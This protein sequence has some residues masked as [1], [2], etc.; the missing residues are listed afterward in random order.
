MPI[1]DEVIELA[2]VKKT[3]TTL[4]ILL[5]A[6]GVAVALAVTF[7]VMYLLKP[8]PEGDN[9]VVN[10]VSITTNSLF[11]SL[12][13][14]GNETLTASIGNKYTV[15]AKASVE[16]GT[17]ENI[18]WEVSPREAVID[19]QIS[20]DTLS[21][22]FTP[23]AGHDGEEVTII[24]RSAAKGE[25]VKE[26]KFKVVDQKTEYLFATKYYAEGTDSS[27]APT[28][29]DNK[30]SVPHYT[31]NDNNKSYTMLFEQK[32]EYNDLINEYA[33][34]TDDEADVTATSGDTNVLSIIRSSYASVT[35]RTVKQGSTTINLTVNSGKTFTFNVTVQSSEDLKYIENIYFF[36]KAIVDKEFIEKH[37]TPDNKL[38]IA[39]LTTEFGGSKPTNTTVKM[40]SGTFTLPYSNE[41]YTNIFDH[42]LIYPINIQYDVK[43]KDFQ[44]NWQ[45]HINVTSS[46]NDIIRPD[47]QTAQNTTTVNLVT[48]GLGSGTLTFEDSASGSVKT[49]QK[50]MYNVVAGNQTGT[51]SVQPYNSDGTLSSTKVGDNGKIAVVPDQKMLYSVAYTLTM[52]GDTDVSSVIDKKLMNLDYMVEFDDD[53][54]EVSTDKEFAEKLKKGVRTQLKKSHVDIVR[55]AG[56]STS[57]TATAFT[58][59][60]SLYVA[61]NANA[62]TTEDT[63][64]PDIKFTKFGTTLSTAEDAA[65]NNRDAQWSKK[66]NVSITAQAKDAALIGKDAA[67]NLV[68]DSDNLPGDITY[69]DNGKGA[70]IH[71]QQ[72]ADGEPLPFNVYELITAKGE[73]KKTVSLDAKGSLRSSTMEPVKNSNGVVVVSG[74]NIVF[75]STISTSKATVSVKVTTMDGGDLGTFTFDIYVIN[76]VDRFA[77]MSDQGV[78]YGYK[79]NRITC[80]SNLT[81]GVSGTRYVYRSYNPQGTAT[82]YTFEKMELYYGAVGDSGK[83]KR[84]EKTGGT[85]AADYYYVYTENEQKHEE[86][87]FTYN[88]SILA[89]AVDLYEKSMKF[90]ENFTTVYAEFTANVSDYYAGKS[91]KTPSHAPSVVQTCNFTRNADSV[92]VY[93]NSGYANDS[94]LI[95]NN[96][97]EYDYNQ[98]AKVYFYATSVVKYS[99]GTEIPVERYKNDYLVERATI[100][101]ASGINETY[102]SDI[103]KPST[104]N[105]YY[106]FQLSVPMVKNN[107]TGDLYSFAVTAGATN[108]NL[109]IRAQNKSRGVAYVGLFSDENCTTP[110]AADTVL[111]FG[112]FN[113]DT[114]ESKTIYVKVTYVELPAGNNPYVN[115]EPV[116]VTLPDFLKSNAENL[117]PSSSVDKVYATGEFEKF[118]LI[119]TL[120]S[121]YDEA[122]N[123]VI[124]VDQ[125]QQPA[126]TNWKKATCNASVDTGLASVSVKDGAITHTATS[127]NSATVEWKVDVA[128]AADFTDGSAKEKVFNLSFASLL[129]AMNY[130][131]TESKLDCTISPATYA[132][133][134]VSKGIFDAD[135]ASIGFTLNNGITEPINKATITVTFTDKTN[136]A[137]TTFTVNFEITV[138]IVVYE[139]TFDNADEVVVFTSGEAGE[140]ETSTTLHVTINGGVTPNDNEL[141]VSVQNADGTTA[142]GLRAVYEKNNEN[143]YTQNVIVYAKNSIITEKTYKVVVSSKGGVKLAEKAITVKTNATYITL[144][145]NHPDVEVTTEEA[146]K[147]YNASVTVTPDKNTFNLAAAI[148]NG[149]DGQTYTVTY[150]V[151]DDAA[152]AASVA[153]QNNGMFTVAP[154][155]RTGQFGYRMTY[156]GSSDKKSYTID[157]VV[158]YTVPS[159][160]NTV[161]LNNLPAAIT[162]NGAIVLYYNSA[163]VRTTID[164]AS[165]IKVTNSFD[166]DGVDIGSMFTERA[167]STASNG[168]LRLEGTKIIPTATTENGVKI[169]IKVGDAES[170]EYTVIVR[171]IGNLVV[172]PSATEIDKT[173]AQ[174]ITLTNSLSNKY[175]GLEYAYAITA[176]AGFTVSGD[177][178]TLTLNDPAP[179][180]GTYRFSAKATFTMTSGI[181]GLA[182][183]CTTFE[184]LNAFNIT[185]NSDSITADFDLICGANTTLDSQNHFLTGGDNEHTV[186]LTKVVS[187]VEYELSVINNVVKITQQFNA[188]GVAKIEVNGSNIGEFTLTVTAKYN[189]TEVVDTVSKTYNFIHI[190]SVTAELKYDNGSAINADT[191][192]NIDDISK[193]FTY[194]VNNVPTGATLDLHAYGEG[195]TTVLNDNVLTITVTKPTTLVVYGTVTVGTGDNQYFVYLPTRTVT[196]T[197]TAPAFNVTSDKN[198]LTLSAGSVLPTATLSVDKAAGFNGAYTVEYTLVSGGDYAALAVNDST[199]TATLTA[200]SVENNGSV[201]VVVRVTVNDGAY[202]GLIYTQEI[203]V[204]VTGVALPTLDLS[205]VI[206]NT[207]ITEGGM[208]N[209]TLPATLNNYSVTYAANVQPDQGI[210]CNLTNSGNTYTLQLNNGAPAGGKIKISVTATIGGAVHSGKTV[211]ATREIIIADPRLGNITN[212][213]LDGSYSCDLSN[214]IRPLYNDGEGYFVKSWDTFTINSIT[215]NGS[216]LSNKVITV[217]GSTVSADIIVDYTMTSGNYKDTN[218]TQQITVSFVQPV[219]VT[220]DY[221]QN[222]ENTATTVKYKSGSTYNS[223]WFTPNRK[224]FTFEGWYLNGKML[225]GSETVED[226]ASLTAKWTES[227]TV[228]VTLKNGYGND[229]GGSQVTSFNATYGSAYGSQLVDIERTGYTFDGWYTEDGRHVTASSIVTDNSAHN[230][231]ARWVANSYKVT[232]Y[233]GNSVFAT[234]TVVYGQ[235]YGTLPSAPDK[236]WVNKFQYWQT[237][238]NKQ[239]KGNDIVTNANNHSLFAKF[240][241]DDGSDTVTI[242]LYQNNSS[243][244]NTVYT[245]L[246]GIVVGSTYTGLDSK[247]PERTGYRFDGWYTARTGGDRII[248]SSL[249]KDNV[250]KLYAHWVKTYTVTLYSNYGGENDGKGSKVYTDTFDTGSEFTRHMATTPERSGYTFMGWYTS[251]ATTTA[252]LSIITVDKNIELFAK[253]ELIPTSY[254]VTLSLNGGKVNNSTADIPNTVNANASFDPNSTTAPTKD[255]FTFIGWFT[256]ASGGNQINEAVTVTEN[257]TF[258]AHWQAI[259]QT[260]TV[261]LNA[262]G[263]T[264]NGGETYAQTLNAGEKFNL[265]NY[266][267]PVRNGYRFDGWYD[268]N[269]KVT[270][271]IETTTTLTANWVEQVTVTFVII[272]ESGNSTLHS[273]KIMDKDTSL[274][275]LPVINDDE[276]Y[277]YGD[278][279]ISATTLISVNTVVSIRKTAKTTSEGDEI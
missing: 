51:L 209:F 101:L 187:G 114:L 62:D 61:V 193:K 151:Y 54:F 238:D 265:H 200:K 259:P 210:N 260:F 231:I 2:P 66:V 16:N 116:V 203:N 37:L 138:T 26:I 64:L 86:L 249:V 207:S 68:T 264:I 156:T 267:V 91:A 32:G 173:D 215:Y 150:S 98:A 234:V 115:F 227:E 190:G 111:S 5:V 251:S 168:I 275:E 134:S 39:K 276:D 239:V 44:T 90:S 148:V 119:L 271:E 278:W 28:V 71:V 100:A 161:T 74:D 243:S 220:F 49:N 78:N 270:G 232:L 118:P 43:T 273:V 246:T 174:P 224:W 19:T 65:T 167:L 11:S 12:G 262:N 146:N 79:L 266:L 204:N 48:R 9:T 67:H 137:T 30:L 256:K 3:K 35:F 13:E 143:K 142:E 263:G 40:N 172:T 113:K 89:P 219:T 164:L 240:S 155:A 70:V 268:S 8:A 245:S 166:T 182:F 230:L 229:N 253:W 183:E 213:L 117:I 59:T 83:F 6:V 169:K 84:V 199:K 73:C 162:D 99:D 22:S 205:T 45:S 50:I 217:N 87:F 218:R 144:D 85:G 255:G 95:V 42:I 211:T 17:S 154:K 46:S 277:T 225:T 233:N 170:Q 53:I 214:L 58:A 88:G 125:Q 261:T 108:S 105:Q 157:V 221:D 152:G 112:K 109:L 76:G 69:L 147:K 94:L 252:A 23:N 247:S 133:I 25:K 208:I 145:A 63:A 36:D 195:V 191:T 197:A 180:N 254:T 141:T 132:G 20:E 27:R 106:S 128:S 171:S 80:D 198:T 14:D 81:A 165:Y 159:S 7:L 212:A 186:R 250:D 194:T 21:F 129:S 160:E 97:K 244:D 228:T 4:I 236:S 104:G 136:G 131:R 248:E 127:T 241:R 92:A 103:K 140:T 176:P 29:T 96:T 121:D 153:N 149:K 124:S 77:P 196:L 158:T 110:I 242:S 34:L 178:T 31:V 181:T 216:T 24:A 179:A 10:D 1:S 102:I 130:N 274:G 72:N 122:D 226:G 55:V 57:S 185:V 222:G 38:D 202:A 75:T 60:V 41:P 184:K 15:S 56:G 175:Y 237:S 192:Q 235:Q 123:G 269:G 126:G 163:D 257:V 206:T 33:L 135:G 52:P 223:N 82:T 279:S 201:K 47:R 189:E 18:A 93:T 188:S 258:Y 272:D 177:K 120:V 139:V 107:T